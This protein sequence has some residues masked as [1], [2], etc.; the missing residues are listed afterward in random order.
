MAADTPTIALVAG[1][2]SGDQLGAA[3]VESLRA[4]YPAARFC[5]VGGQ[6]MQAAGV[7]AWWDSEE[8][9]VMGLF[10]VLEHFPRLLRL[11]RDLHRR[12]LNARPD[13]FVGIDAPDFN[14][15]LEIKLRRADI[16]TVQYVSPTVWAWRQGRVRKVRRAADLVMCLFPFEPEFYAR[17]DVSATYVGHPM[18]DQIEPDENP[19]AAR[20]ALGL[21]PAAPTVALLPGSRAS[22]V[23]LLAGPMIEA[24]ALLRER[25]PGL[26]FVAAMASDRT[27]GIFEQAMQDLGRTDI[28]LIQ[29]RPRQ[30][31]AAASVVLCASGTATLETMLVNRP[32]VM[33]YRITRPTY[34]LAKHLKLIRPQL[35]ALPNILAGEALV[36]ELMQD[37]ASGANLARAALHWLEHP[38]EAAALRRRF[39][40]LHE[41]LRCRASDQAA[42]AVASVIDR[43]PAT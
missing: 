29:G 39:A 19:G 34:L 24:V 2:S 4:R 20:A 16:R 35:F 43:E 22:E 42:A 3:L 28:A 10:E 40:G 31:M 14:L 32:M 21:D 7:E 5:G 1:E 17:H 23:G 41:Q 36:P 12:L 38:Q 8:L 13:V 37:E 15:G 25:E 27:R 18:A 9:A 30:V 33:T 26:Q 6:R 11:R